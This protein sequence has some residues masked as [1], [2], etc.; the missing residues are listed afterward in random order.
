[1]HNAVQSQG[2]SASDIDAVVLFGMVFDLTNYESSC[3][4]N[5]DQAIDSTANPSVVSQVARYW[6]SV[7]AETVFAIAALLPRRGK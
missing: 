6:R 1:M 5:N 4:A 7:T 2:L 3:T